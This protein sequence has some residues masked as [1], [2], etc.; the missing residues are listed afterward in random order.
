LEV[1]RAVWSPM[2]PGKRPCQGEQLN[3]RP[4]NWPLKRAS[5]FWTKTGRE[6]YETHRKRVHRTEKKKKV[7]GFLTWG[8]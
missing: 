5:K 6:K 1:V 4:A 2:N 3:P 7:T 8:S